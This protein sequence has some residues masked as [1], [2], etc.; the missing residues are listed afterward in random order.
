M[1]ESNFESNN[2]TLERWSRVDEERLAAALKGPREV[3]LP[4]YDGHN[5]H[6]CGRCGKFMP[7]FG[8]KC[9]APT[10]KCGSEADWGL[11]ENT[12][13]GCSRPTE[14]CECGQ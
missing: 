6:Y 1:F 3:A 9:V 8:H 4:S 12:C 5:A 13:R 14:Y 7:E 10:C 11:Y 2:V